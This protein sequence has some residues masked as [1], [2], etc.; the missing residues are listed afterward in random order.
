MHT[1]DYMRDIMLD[2]IGEE[3][4]EA[5]MVIDDILDECGW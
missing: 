1:R 3:S 4:V 5:E 2:A